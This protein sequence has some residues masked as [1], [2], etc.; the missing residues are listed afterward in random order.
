MWHQIVNKQNSSKG[1]FTKHN[2]FLEIHIYM[3]LRKARITS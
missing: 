1:N 3:K 2:V